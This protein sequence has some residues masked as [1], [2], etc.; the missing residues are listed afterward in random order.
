MI[1]VQ[2]PSCKRI[3][4]T[5]ENALGR[6]AQCKDCGAAFTV[7]AMPDAPAPAAVEHDLAAAAAAYVSPAAYMPPPAATTATAEAAVPA[8]AAVPLVELGEARNSSRP[9][10]IV[11]ICFYWAINAVGV[12]IAGSV[13]M[14]TAMG[15]SVASGVM[16]SMMRGH[17]YRDDI[18]PAALATAFGELVGA[19]IFHYGLL[20]LAAVYGLWSNRRWGLSLSRGI[21]VA[22]TFL[23]LVFLIIAVIVRGG[24]LAGLLSTI[25]SV[26]ILVYLFG[27]L[28]LDTIR[29][30]IRGVGAAT[31]NAGSYGDPRGQP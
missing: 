6:R 25:L 21:A 29:R 7:E 13:L 3:H 19:I 15:G 5:G 23:N 16:S 14:A 10:G 17:S 4:K 27:R 30:Q 24:I 22:G 11:W 2:C 8:A 12:V 28:N 20:Q 9:F 1:N 26:L 31:W 18:G